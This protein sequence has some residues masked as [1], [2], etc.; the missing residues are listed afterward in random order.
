MSFPGFELSRTVSNFKKRILENCSLVFM[1][2]TKHKI[3]QFYGNKEMCKKCDFFAVFVVI[4]APYCCKPWLM[5]CTGKWK[6]ITLLWSF[7]YWDQ[8][9]LFADPWK[10]CSIYHPLSPSKIFLRCKTTLKIRICFLQDWISV[11]YSSFGYFHGD[12]RERLNWRPKIRKFRTWN[13]ILT[14]IVCPVRPISHRGSKWMA[15]RKFLLFFTDRAVFVLKK[16]RANITAHFF[17][18]EFEAEL[19]VWNKCKNNINIPC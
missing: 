9:L 10:C 13:V 7:S 2:L 6:H 3:R 11:V 17:Y 15:K 8:S 18:S 12:T 1:F 4:R 19:L 16:Y 5:H 14:M